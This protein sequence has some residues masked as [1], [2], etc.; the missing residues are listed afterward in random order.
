[1]SLFDKLAEGLNDVDVSDPI[2]KPGSYT[3]KIHS[4][5]KKS[6]EAGTFEWLAISLQ[7]VDEG[8]DLAGNPLSGVFINH[9]L[10]LTE[11]D[12]NSEADIL[13]EV[14]RFLDCFSDSRDFDETLES[15]VGEE[16]VVKTRVA[17]ER[18]GKN[19]EVYPETHAISRNGFIPRG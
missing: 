7:L 6:N 9:M 15:Y 1:M 3:F 18:E 17:K 14:A 12:Y 11:N 16:G 19:G 2:L 5:E 10:G 4:I 13:R 8:E